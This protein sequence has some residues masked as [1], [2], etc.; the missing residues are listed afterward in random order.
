[1]ASKKNKQSY[2]KKQERMTYTLGEK[3]AAETACENNQR[4]D[5]TD[6]LQHIHYKYIQKGLPGGPVVTTLCFHLRGLGFDP[7]RAEVLYAV[8][9]GQNKKREKTNIRK[10]KGNHN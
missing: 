9:C 2:V 4:V 10:S 3:Q 7:S 1:M 5:L 8:R 6:R